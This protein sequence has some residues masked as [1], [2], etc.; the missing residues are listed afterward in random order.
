MSFTATCT[1]CSQKS[2]SPV[3]ARRGR[4]IGE[5]EHCGFVAADAA[6]TELMASSTSPSA[7]DHTVHTEEAFTLGLIGQHHQR[8]ALYERLAQRKSNAWVQ[9]TGRPKLRVLE[10]GCG[11]AGL[12]EPLKQ[13]GHEYVGIDIDQRVIDAASERGV[14]ARH[15]DLYEVT[16][17]RRFDVVFFSQVLEHS[18][19]PNAFLSHVH[20]LLEPGGLAVCD[21][22]N[23][24]SMAGMVARYLRPGSAR[25]GGIELPHHAYAYTRRSLAFAFNRHFTAVEVFTTSSDDPIWG[26][27]IVPGF[28]VKAYHQVSKT[29]KWP[30]LVVAVGRRG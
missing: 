6:P 29:L 20:R 4:L 10:V 24:H 17:E 28:A 14:D 12:A 7:N 21:V 19:E 3:A 1:L 27:A 30:S 16:G 22:P 26:Q 8:A 15:Q 23:H 11:A 18:T 13:H 5:C 9:R 25:Y 2:V